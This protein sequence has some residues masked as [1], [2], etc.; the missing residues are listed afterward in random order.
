M[1]TGLKNAQ[2]VKDSV[3]AILADPH[4]SGNLSGYVGPNNPNLT[5]RSGDLSKQD[6]VTK[7]P[8]G[9]VTKTTVQGE[10]IPEIQTTKS[11][12]TDLNGV[13]TTG[14]PQTTLT[15]ATI[16]IDDRTS[17]GDTPGVMVHESVH[18]GEAKANP[19]QFSKDAA[20]E[21]SNPNHDARPQEQR[22]NTAQKAYTKEIKQ[23]VKQI[24]KD[25]KKENQ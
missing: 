24:E 12:S 8:D 9:S 19:A 23:A 22:A 15:D 18:A 1:W 13:T 2:L 17:T 14:P 4:T 11:S 7:N 16:T 3:Q 21:K 10:T 6:T 5:I 25:R 20:A